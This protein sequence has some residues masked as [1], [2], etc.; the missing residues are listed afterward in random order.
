[1]IDIIS[2]PI[3]K[4]TKILDSEQYSVRRPFSHYLAH[5]QTVYEKGPALAKIISKARKNMKYR[6]KMKQSEITM[7]QYSL[8]D[9][10]SEM[11]RYEK[12]HDKFIFEQYRQLFASNALEFFVKLKGGFLQPP[13]YMGRYLKKLDPKIAKLLMRLQLSSNT[14]MQLKQAQKLFTD[15]NRLAGHKLCG[16]IKL[17]P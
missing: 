6:T 11:Q 5:S 14:R 10:L 1:M 9:F 3:I 12:L 7:H 13:S 2:D 4:A 15:L 17:R 16:D 8:D